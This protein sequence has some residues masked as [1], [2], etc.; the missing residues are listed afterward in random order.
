MALMYGAGKLGETDLWTVVMEWIVPRPDAFTQA[1]ASELQLTQNG[2]GTMRVIP[3]ALHFCT[4]SSWR[5]AA[6]QN[7][8]LSGSP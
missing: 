6:S 8:A 5:R 7:A 2:R 1:I 4:S 3:Q